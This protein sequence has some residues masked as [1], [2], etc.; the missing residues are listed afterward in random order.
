MKKE[1]CITII[2][3]GLG[4]DDLSGRFLRI[5]ESAPVLIGGKRLL[6]LFPEHT[7]EKIVIGK[8]AATLVKNLP[9]KLQKKKA[10][11]L[12]SGDPNFHGIAALFYEHF[13]KDQIKVIPNITAFQAAFAH[14]NEPWNSAT[15]ISVHGRGITACDAII[16]MPGVCAVYCDGVNTPAAVAAYL[17]EKDSGL[18]KSAAWV[19]EC[20]GTDKEKITSGILKK[21]LQVTASPLS[22][23]I[24]KKEPCR[25]C[26]S[27]GIPD[28]LFA[29]D[30]AMITRRDV[31]LMALARLELEDGLVLW[32]IGA[33]SGSVAIE[34]ANA[35]PRIQAHAIEKNIRRFSQLKANIRRF[36]TPNVI[37]LHGAAA[38]VCAELPRPDRVFIGGSGGELAAIL[39]IIQKNLGDDAIVVV[40][41]VTLDTL[42][43]VLACLKKWRWRYEVTSVHNARLDSDS[44]PVI[45]R[46][47][48][49]VFI[50]Q[51]RAGLKRE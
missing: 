19:F 18:A 13:P 7:G 9:K 50:V 20:L 23:M 2:G 42:D 46:S 34:A 49:P 12:A 27:L 37:P 38:E 17:L 29:H 28:Y 11:V 15:F 24:V 26:Q 30:R 45:F 33:G 31:R 5:V 40:N 47:E 44:R 41:C 3:I 21:M 39:K 43:T 1:P 8:A 32:D 51:G 48:N 36:R 25:P 4:R 22:M 10:V 35:Y 16:R 6:S 14:I